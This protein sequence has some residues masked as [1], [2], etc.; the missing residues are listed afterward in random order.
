VRFLPAMTL[1]AAVLAAGCAG[2][3]PRDDAAANAPAEHQ[4][5]V[6]SIDEIREGQ[7][8][9]L[10]NVYDLL[11]R[12]HPEWMRTVRSTSGNA[13]PTVWID[14]Q[15][16][17]GLSVLRTM[18]IGGVTLLRYLTP[19][20]ARGELGFDNPGGAIVVSMH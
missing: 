16:M 3:T 11:Q 17:G 18:P 15:R 6:M 7:N 14:L 12:Y 19:P 1:A 5:N 8:L 2:R 13:T 10:G 4:R 9:G 20:E